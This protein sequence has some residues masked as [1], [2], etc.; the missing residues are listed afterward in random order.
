MKRKKEIAELEGIRPEPIDPR[1]IYAWENYT[2]KFL[3]L[4]KDN[5]ER[6]SCSVNIEYSD[7]E[8]KFYVDVNTNASW[9][10]A[11]LRI[12]AEALGVDLE[13]NPRNVVKVSGAMPVDI[14]VKDAVAKIDRMCRVAELSAEAAEDAI[15][16]L[17]V[18]IN[19]SGGGA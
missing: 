2:R 3:S 5:I 6:G 15:A 13:Y 8:G 12:M 16:K 11:R 7:E 9:S 17:V 14:S 1:L 18:E 10:G 4:V 19:G